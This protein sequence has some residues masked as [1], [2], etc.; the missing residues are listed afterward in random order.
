[1]ER[2]RGESEYAQNILYVILK[3]QI[4]MRK[5]KECYKIRLG[6]IE[7]TEHQI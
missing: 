3:E 4:E 5:I 6:K 1:M 7:V 2:V